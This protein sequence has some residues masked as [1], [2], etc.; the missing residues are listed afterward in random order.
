MNQEQLYSATL[1]WV[2]FLGAMVPA[3]YAWRRTRE[4][5]TK[6][7]KWNRFTQRSAFSGLVFLSVFGFVAYVLWKLG[8]PLQLGVAEPGRL[9]A[10]AWLPLLTVIWASLT[11]L[12]LL[13]NTRKGRCEEPS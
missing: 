4:L 13:V 12:V 9:P 2:L 5:G 3:W 11:Y 8:A 1:I 10:M 7:P 6:L